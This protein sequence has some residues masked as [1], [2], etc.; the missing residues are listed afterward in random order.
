MQYLK[1]IDS[2]S[3]I[4]KNYGV[5]ILSDSKFW[6]I[7]TDSY[8]F[9]A[10]YTLKD[11]FRDCISSGKVSSLVSL[12]GKKKE[13]IDYIRNIVKS[14]NR[15]DCQ[16]LIACLFSIAIALGSCRKSDY[17]S[18]SQKSPNGSRHNPATPSPNTGGKQFP[19]K[20]LSPIITGLIALFGGSLLYLWFLF[21]GP[22]MFWI[23]CLIAIMQLG[24]CK[25]F[26]DTLERKWSIGA[27]MQAYSCY[28][29]I[30]ICFILNSLVPFFLMSDTLADGIFSYFSGQ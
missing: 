24:S 5:G 17:S 29:P 2:V 1:L 15:K 14:D 26:S 22:A 21:D 30:L 18:F 7:L 9:A 19:Y 4:V 11:E 23:L 25:Y 13:T 8:S 27:K 12:K 20:I 16:N 10:D 28:L 6:S 3:T